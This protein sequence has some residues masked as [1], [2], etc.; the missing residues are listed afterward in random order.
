MAQKKLAAILLGRLLQEMPAKYVS[1]QEPEYVDKYLKALAM[2]DSL[3][4]SAEDYPRLDFLKFLADYVEGQAD[5]DKPEE[6]AEWQEG[7]MTMAA[8]V[9]AAW[10]I[11]NSPFEED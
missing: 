6:S 8:Q 9:K 4:M 11:Y 1:E 2:A 3:G 10:G 5:P 7:Y